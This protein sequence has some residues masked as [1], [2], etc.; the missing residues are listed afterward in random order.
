MEHKAVF[1]E[2]FGSFT[3]KLLKEAY[4][5]LLEFN[6]LVYKHPDNG[7]FTH[8]A[9]CIQL[10]IDACGDSVESAVQELYSVINMYVN[11]LSIHC[12]SMEE[13]VQNVIDTVYSNSE[14]KNR[15]FIEYNEAKRDYLKYYV[16]VPTERFVLWE[17]KPDEVIAKAFGVDLK[18]IAKRRKEIE[19]ELI[20][21]TPENMASDVKLEEQSVL[22]VDELDAVLEGYNIDTG[23]GA[24]Q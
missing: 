7:I 11:T 10:E 5:T 20:L 19:D 18:C 1:V 4:P 21:L 17:D 2:A 23:R 16:Q 3:C 6:V 14:Q 8:T 13:W 24:V 15:L 9:V 12:N 22:T